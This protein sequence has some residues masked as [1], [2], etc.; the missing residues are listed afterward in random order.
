[1]K[2]ICRR[3]TTVQHKSS[4]YLQML[5]FKVAYIHLKTSGYNQVNFS[6]RGFHS[7]TIRHKRLSVLHTI[8]TLIM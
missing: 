1:M 7:K 3:T 5:Q 8:R 6:I 4:S 2:H